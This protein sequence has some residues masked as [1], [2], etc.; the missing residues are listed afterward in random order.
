LA[1][2]LKVDFFFFFEGAKQRLSILTFGIK[3]GATNLKAQKTD[4]NDAKK[5]D[6]V[7]C[8]LVAKIKGLYGEPRP[9]PDKKNLSL[10]KKN[11]ISACLQKTS[12]EETSTHANRSN[13]QPSTGIN[14]QEIWGGHIELRPSADTFSMG[15]E[16]L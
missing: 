2:R 5:K 8:I 13:L 12:I 16:G 10:K 6:H 15:D 3:I 9:R 4:G 11:P 7:V 1:R 14:G